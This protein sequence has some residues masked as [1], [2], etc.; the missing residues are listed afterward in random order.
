MI[1][2]DDSDGIFWSVSLT[3]FARNSNPMK[4]LLSCMMTSSNENIF[5]VTDHLCGEFTGHR[6]TPRTK[7]SDAGVNNRQAGDLR[8]HRAH[9]DVTVMCN[10]IT[11]GDNATYFAHAR[12]VQMSSLVQNFVAIILSESR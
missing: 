2:K 1:F 8:R 3:D 4:I 10:S 9:Y 5:R 11:D 12:T 6:R 7:A